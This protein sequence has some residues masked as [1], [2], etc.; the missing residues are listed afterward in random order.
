MRALLIH[1]AF[2][3]GTMAI[4]TFAG[5]SARPGEW[6]AA[7]EKPWFTPP[8]WAFGPI[9]TVLYVLIGWAGARAFLRR[10]P[11]AIWVA[12]MAVNLSWSPVFFGLHLTTAG[13]AIIGGLLV[14]ILAF[15]AANW[16]RDR[17]ASALFVP[18]AVW[19]SLATAVNA[20]VVLLN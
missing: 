7:L 5:L 20:G 16:A 4:G 1:A 15:I 14:L 10:G 17:L 3:A 13:L 2:I 11:F 6:Y 12:Q 18:Y 19:I 9:W 8:P